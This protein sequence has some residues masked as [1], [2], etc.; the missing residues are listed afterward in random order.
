MRSFFTDIL[1]GLG[2]MVVV[3][4]SI[5]LLAQYRKTLGVSTRDIETTVKV[6]ALTFDDGPSGSTDQVLKILREKDVQATFFVVGKHI[7]KNPELLQ[8]IYFS[9]HQVGNHSYSHPV[10]YFMNQTD[11]IKEFAQTEDLVFE[12]IKIRPSIIRVPFGWYHQ[13][14]MWRLLETNHYQIIDWNV[15][16]MDWK[17]ASAQKIVDEVISSVEPGSIILLH[18]GPPE[19]DRTPTI[20][21]LPKIIDELYQKGYQFVTIEELMKLNQDHLLHSQ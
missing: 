18:D 4:L 3:G 11:I 20:E 1:F 2:L 14:N 10:M 9:G 8:E 12:L 5:N 7:E 15:D 17:R 13:L 21:A 6:V 16:P 19:A